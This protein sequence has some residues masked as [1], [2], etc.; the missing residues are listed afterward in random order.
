MI[1]FSQD[2]KFLCI[3]KL[4]AIGDVSHILPIIYTLKKL[5]PK[6]TITW[7]IGKLEYQL[8]KTL[9]DVEYIIF[10]KSKGWRAF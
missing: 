4:S 10:D 7:V 5:W 6:T 8:A 1:N 9:P 3:L 2:P